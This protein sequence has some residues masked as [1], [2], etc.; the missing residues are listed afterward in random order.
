MELCNC[1]LLSFEEIFDYRKENETKEICFKCI[2]LEKE[3]KKLQ[4]ENKMLKHKVN[5]YKSRKIHN[6]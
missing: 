4:K 6:K 3:I 2:T 1:K 5:M